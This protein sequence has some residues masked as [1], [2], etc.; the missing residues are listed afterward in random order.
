VSAG[1]S[2]PTVSHNKESLT[3]SE[4]CPYGVEQSVGIRPALQRAK[5]A[6]RTLGRRAVEVDLMKVELYRADGLGLR[7]IATKLKCSVEQR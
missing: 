4:H 5:R 2:C 1:L 3:T 7:A 6:G